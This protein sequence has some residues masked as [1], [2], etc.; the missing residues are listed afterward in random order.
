MTKDVL[1]TPGSGNIDF[2]NLDVTQAYIRLEDDND[3]VIVTNS[4]NLVIGDASS[5]IYIGDGTANIDIVF[6]ADGEIR[7]SG[8][9][10]ITL[11]SAGD[12]IR[13]GS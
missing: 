10:T 8:N 1:I 12:S 13:Y 11:G 2:K 9:Q 6:P 3:L 4:G 5:D 7:G